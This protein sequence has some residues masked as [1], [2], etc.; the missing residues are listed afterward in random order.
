MFYT[1][2]LDRLFFFVCNHVVNWNDVDDGLV[3]ILQFQTEWKSRTDL[4]PYTGL[5]LF[6]GSPPAT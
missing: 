6:I 1:V 5:V 4:L 3:L 2:T